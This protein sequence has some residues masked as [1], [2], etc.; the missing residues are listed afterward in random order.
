MSELMVDSR[1]VHE[2]I[3]TPVAESSFD[4]CKAR[5][6]TLRIIDHQAEGLDAELGQVGNVGRLSGRGQHAQSI[7]MELA[8]KGVPDA[9]GGTPVV[10]SRRSRYLALAVLTL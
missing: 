8:R 5:L 3:K 1:I 4:I 10:I 2:I 9:A 7:P 6:D